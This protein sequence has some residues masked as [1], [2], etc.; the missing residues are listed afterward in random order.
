MPFSLGTLANTVLLG[1]A[2]YGQGRILGQD[3]AREQAAQD[4]ARK[5]RVMNDLLTRQLTSARIQDLQNR[6]DP[7]KVIEARTQGQMQ[8][9][10]AKPKR[11]DPNSPEGIAARIQVKGARPGRAPGTGAGG[12]APARPGSPAAMT[13]G[14]IRSAQQAQQRLRRLE[15]QDWH[16]AVDPNISNVI[17]NAGRIPVVGGLVQAVAGPTA[18]GARSS[19][20]QTYRGDQGVFTHTYA[21]ALPGRR[22]GPELLAIIDKNF[23]PPA[24]TTDPAVVESYSRRREE[25]L[26]N[27]ARA[28]AGEPVDLEAGLF[29]LDALPRDLMVPNADA[30]PTPTQSRPGSPRSQRALDDYLARVRK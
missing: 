5:Q 16:N 10:A 24:G 17:E 21:S 29:G 2:A 13:A 8:V 30:T 4:E 28:A 11:I 9:N 23:F 3:Q 14:A 15:Q 22:L 26:N 6:P 12:A 18:Q 25:A 1:R 7:Y 20:R 27:L 19:G